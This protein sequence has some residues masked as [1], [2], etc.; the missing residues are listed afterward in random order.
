M[1][2][3]DTFLR[4]HLYELRQNNRLSEEYRVPR[5]SSHLGSFQEGCQSLLEMYKG[6]H[7]LA[8][9]FVDT[10]WSGEGSEHKNESGPKPE[11]RVLTGHSHKQ[12][13]QHRL[14]LTT[15]V[16][17]AIDSLLPFDNSLLK[18]IISR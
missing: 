1:N 2:F 15:G 14:S 8:R 3:T 7:L 18:I 10:L 13:E 9:L 5:D 16:N 6:N 11:P 4:Y 17:W 12:S